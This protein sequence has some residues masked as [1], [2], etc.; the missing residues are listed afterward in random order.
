MAT[1]TAQSQNAATFSAQSQN[2]ATFTAQTVSVAPGIWD[3][4][5]QPWLLS[6]PWQY[7]GTGYPSWT[8]QTNS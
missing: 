4:S 8:A 3:S 7:A 5:V 1:W 6:L 2:S